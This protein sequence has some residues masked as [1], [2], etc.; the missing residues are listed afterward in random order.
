MP[1]KIC[2]YGTGAIGGLIAARLANTPA[3]VSCVAREATLNAIQDRG[4][5]LIEGNKET[6]VNL[7]VTGDT[8]TLGT[9]DIVIVTLK[10]HA[11][12]ENITHI[13]K[14]LSPESIVLTAQN[15]LPWWYFYQDKSCLKK[16]HLKSVDPDGEIWKTLRPE[17]AIG[18]VVYPAANV[19][20]P[21]VVQHISGKRFSLGEPNGIISDR[22]IALSNVFKAADFDITLSNDI[23]SEIWLKLAVNAGTNPLSLIHKVTIGELLD[24]KILRSQLYQAIS[25][26][27]N[28]AKKLGVKI[29]MQPEQLLNALEVVRGHKTSMLI[30]FENGR[31]LELNGLMHSI[32][33]IAKELS[34]SIQTLDKLGNEIN[35]K[36][37][38]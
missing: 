9:Q 33:E 32:I 8:S 23:R 6:V 15:G 38:Q 3:D 12:K 29:I 27:Q 17:R 28:V 26:S 36:L 13:A 19:I 5:R 21:G 34:V 25:D 31:K 10:T 2:I 16:Q 24:S 22:L 35:L 11:I 14:L 37:L 4:L 7:K 1:L 18:S 30:D 20:K